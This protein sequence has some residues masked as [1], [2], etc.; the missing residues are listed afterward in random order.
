MK[1][2]FKAESRAGKWA[3]GFGFALVVSMVLSVVFAL[4]I[5][6]DSKVVENNIFLSTVAAILSII[7]TLSAPLSFFVGVYAIIRHKE[8]AIIKPLAIFYLATLI[9]FLIGEF[10]FPH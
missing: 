8:W 2:N 4:L 10:T 1:I 5:G 9:M 6:G 7:F 3:I